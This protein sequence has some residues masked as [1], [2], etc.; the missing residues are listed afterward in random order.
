MAVSWAASSCT[1]S[2]IPRW[3]TCA[4]PRDAAVDPFPGVCPFH[5]D[6]LEG[7][8][9]GPA[10]LARW[11]RA[12]E[13]LPPEH[14]GLGPR[15]PLPRAGPRQPHLHAVSAAHRHGW[16]RDGAV[17]AV[18]PRPPRGERA[19]QRLRPG[20]RGPRGHRTLRRSPRAWR[21]GR[22]RSAPSP[23]P[24]G[25]RRER[26]QLRPDRDRLRPGRREGRGAGGL[27]RQARRPRRAGAAPGRGRRQHRD[28]A[29]Q[30]A[31]RDGAL[32]L[33]AA[34]ARAL[35]HRLQ[36]QAASSRSPTSCTARTRSC[37]A[38]GR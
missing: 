27:L 36:H 23:S 9:S 13:A 37:A 35:R 28:G 12:A 10:L 20:P 15:G 30:D 3:A 7:L 16:R 22:R 24:R 21:K 14:R 29:E 26:R 4:F 34:P 8:A 17:A 11:G 38:C 1:A 2:S 18:P 31:A 32:L 5:G 25:A 6:C 19:P 33:G